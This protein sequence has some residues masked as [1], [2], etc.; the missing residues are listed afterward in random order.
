MDL[1]HIPFEACH[2]RAARAR[3]LMDK[4]GIDVLLITPSKNLRYLAGFSLPRSERFVALLFRMESE[5]VAIGPVFERERL[6]SSPLKMQLKL[7]RD[8]QCPMAAVRDVVG[9]A[10]GITVALEPRTDYADYM[11]LVREIP[12]VR[13]VDGSVIFDQL[14]AE[15]SELE[16]KCLEAAIAIT[17]KV[18]AR[19]P[20]LLREGM[21]ER[22]LA[23]LLIQEMRGL[24]GKSCEA[25][26]QFGENAAIPHG[27]SGHRKLS[28]GDLI[29][30]DM[31]T[32]VSGYHSDLT[33][34][35][36]YK[37]A[38]EAQRQVYGIVKRAQEA[39]REKTEPG[40]R[41]EE[42]D[43]IARGVID[44]YEYGVYFPHRTGHGT[45]L[46]GHEA[47]Y[48]VKGNTQE[49]KPG[50]VITI[51]PGVY[52]P[53]RFGIRLEDQFLV[54]DRGARMLSSGPDETLKV[55]G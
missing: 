47:P 48:L 49:L 33:R 8:D 9:D 26:V 24:G 46:S 5:P 52:L 10:P 30:I 6:L 43:D 2:R 55:V 31:G 36:A 45:G 7:C 54:T 12:E 50:M 35:Y 19:V 29:L 44:F 42:I 4:H 14:R 39:A 11:R 13:W 38:N 23:R 15:K 37:N 3:E 53:G 25:V 27:V 28:F 17:E 32:S 18:F 41:A 16:I 20:S 22:A 40:V 1:P 51:E 34:V 21:E